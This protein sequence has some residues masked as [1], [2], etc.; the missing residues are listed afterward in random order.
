MLHLE[1]RQSIL[2]A[3]R[4]RQRKFQVILIRHG[5]HAEGL[6]QVIATANELNVPVRY[7]DGRELDSL[8]H[9][10]SHGGVVA[11][12]SAKPRAAIED[13][14]E[15]IRTVSGPALLLLLEGVDDA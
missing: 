14:I 15:L 7:V 8:V 13:V 10:A 5:S 3:L 9:G 4:G 2:A 6:D 11:I 12:C 1:G